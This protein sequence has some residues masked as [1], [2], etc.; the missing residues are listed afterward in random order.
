MIVVIIL[1]SPTCKCYNV[2]NE[3]IEM[4]RVA[5]CED[6]AHCSAELET[7]CHAIFE[8]LMIEYELDVFDSSEAF[9]HAFSEEHRRFDL[10]LLDIVMAQPNG[11]E[12]AQRIRQ[13]GAEGAIVFVTSNRDYALQGYDVR[14]LHYLMKPVDQAVLERVI[15]ADYQERFQTSFFVF[16]MGQQKLRVAL[17]DIITLETVGRRVAVTLR[18]D[19][20]FFSGKLTTLLALLPMEQFVRCHQAFALNIRN[21]RELTGNE[22]VT[23]T[24]KCVPVSRSFTKDV[25]RAFVRCLRGF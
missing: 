15:S 5:L 14:A 25:Q 17:K 13:E 10:M 20:V 19:T 23:V 11:M 2:I 1:Y 12:L 7:A 4:Y 18:G 3:V 16:E 21:V 6:E 9:L 22:A 24:G 8:K